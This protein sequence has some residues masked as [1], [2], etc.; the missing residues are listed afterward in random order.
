MNRFGPRIELTRIL[1][2]FFWISCLFL[3]RDPGKERFSWNPNRFQNLQRHHQVRWSFTWISHIDDKRR[4]FWPPASKKC[5]SRESLNFV[6]ENRRLFLPANIYHLIKFKAEIFNSSF[7]F[8]K[9][10]RHYDCSHLHTDSDLSI[11]NRLFSLSIIIKKIFLF[12][13]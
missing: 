9:H 4:L 1:S 7:F 5:N 10:E 2:Q 6:G 11:F 12:S 13:D 3:P 8:F